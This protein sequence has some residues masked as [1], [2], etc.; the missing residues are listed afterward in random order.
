MEVDRSGSR[1]EHEL[2]TRFLAPDPQL[3][4]F[5]RC[6]YNSPQTACN[7]WVFHSPEGL[8][9]IRRFRG[10]NSMKK[11]EAENVQES[12]SNSKKRD[13]L[14]KSPS[15]TDAR[16]RGTAKPV[17][18]TDDPRF[19]QAVQNYRGWTV[20]HARSHKYDRAKSLFEKVVAGPSPELADRAARSSQHL[21]TANEPRLGELQDSRRTLR[22]R[23]LSHEHGRLRQGARGFPGADAEAPKLD[24]VWYGTAALNCLMG[25]FPDAIAGLNEAIRSQSRQPIPGSKR[26]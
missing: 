25:H 10:C 14:Q 6:G 20:S 21:H 8:S 22:L 12:N 5:Q 18:L 4:Q 17:K 1:C 26:F 24:F 15:P 11:K 2:S 19:S 9:A 23:R 3:T 7:T 16:P 13:S